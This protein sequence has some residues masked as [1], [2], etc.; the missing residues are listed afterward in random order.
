MQGVFWVY[1]AEKIVESFD[2]ACLGV[3]NFVREFYSGGIHIN[4]ARASICDNSALQLTVSIG[5]STQTYIS[6]PK[7]VSVD[8]F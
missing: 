6:V 8:M 4:K 3:C 5:I 2:D 7:P 1:L